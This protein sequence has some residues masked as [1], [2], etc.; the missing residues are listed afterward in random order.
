MMSY[1]RRFKIGSAGTNNK[2]GTQEK[3]GKKKDYVLKSS[4]PSFAPWFHLN[5]GSA[6]EGRRERERGERK[7]KKDLISRSISALFRLDSWRSKSRP[8]G[9]GERGREKASPVLFPGAGQSSL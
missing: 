6:R 2:A 7:K 4:E 9:D 5:K 1:S 3:K 8:T